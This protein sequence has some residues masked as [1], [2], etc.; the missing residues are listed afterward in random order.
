MATL[1]EYFKVSTQQKQT[2]VLIRMC[3]SSSLHDKE[4]LSQAETFFFAV[5][6]YVTDNS[7]RFL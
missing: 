1:Y 3:Q 5:L 7:V 2:I 6:N 4:Q